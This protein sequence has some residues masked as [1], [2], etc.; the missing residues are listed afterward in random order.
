MYAFY[1][2]Y[3]LD[4]EYDSV[5][6]YLAQNIKNGFSAYEIKIHQFLFL[7]IECIYFTDFVT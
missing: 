4:V 5:E 1:A 6:E 2:A 7:I 3:R